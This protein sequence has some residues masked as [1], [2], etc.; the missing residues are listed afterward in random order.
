MKIKPKYM[1]LFTLLLGFAGFGLRWWLFSTG[2]DEKGLL[3]EGHPANYLTFLLAALA[4]GTLFLWSQK[5]TKVRSHKKLYPASAVALLGCIAAAGGIGLTT[6]YE[7]QGKQDLITAV[8]VALA[9]LAFV[10]V[11]LLGVGRKKG[12]RPNFLMQAFLTVYLMFHL[13]SQYRQWSSEPQLQLYCFQLLASVCLMLSAFHGAVL[14]T[15]VG[16]RRRYVFF[17]QGALFFCCMSLVGDFWFFYLAMGIFCAT[18]VCSLQDKVY[19]A[20]YLKKEDA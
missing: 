7:L 17:N 3:E 15:Q 12:L 8:T 18:N 2:V 6:F 4:V 11:I 14:D 13:V 16:S 10:S 5:L 20:K 9:G 1:P 19:Q